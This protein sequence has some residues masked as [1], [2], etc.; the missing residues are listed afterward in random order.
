MPALLT[1]M[2]SPPNSSTAFGARG[3]PVGLARD[4]VPDERGLA[5]GVGDLLDRGL[6]GLNLDVG[7]EH[8]GALLGEPLG[9]RLADPA[10]CAGHEGYSAFQPVHE[11]SFP[12]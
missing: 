10:R 9:C 6:A 12:E 8:G 3:L 2:S 11:R 1:R 4:V 7:D 5:A